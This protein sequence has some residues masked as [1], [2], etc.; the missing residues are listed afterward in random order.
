MLVILETVARTIGYAAL[1]SL[2]GRIPS[3]TVSRLL[4]L[5]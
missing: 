2:A 1:G 3:T 5:T 4:V